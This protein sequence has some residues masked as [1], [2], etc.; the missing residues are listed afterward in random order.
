MHG[1]WNLSCSTCHSTQ[2]VLIDEIRFLASLWRCQ[3][4]VFIILFNL[5]TE[6]RR[7]VREREGGGEDSRFSHQRSQR[8]PSQ[9]FQQQGSRFQ[10]PLVRIQPG[11][12]DLKEND[13]SMVRQERDSNP[14]DSTLGRECCGPSVISARHLFACSL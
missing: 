3:Q 10:S 4:L 2:N 11:T 14:N 7:V 9:E 1:G 5:H 6:N 12:I 13:E 8:H